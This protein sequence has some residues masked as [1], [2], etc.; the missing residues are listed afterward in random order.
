MQY[1]L[2]CPCNTLTG[3]EMIHLAQQHTRISRILGIA[4]N[5]RL[6]ADQGHL[7]DLPTASCSEVDQKLLL[8][9]EL[10]FTEDDAST[11]LLAS[12]YSA[13]FKAY[14]ESQGKRCLVLGETTSALEEL[15]SILYAQLDTWGKALASYHRDYLGGLSLLG[16]PQGELSRPGDILPELSADNPKFNYQTLRKP[17]TEVSLQ[18]ILKAELAVEENAGLWSDLLQQ[19]NLPK[20]SSGLRMRCLKDLN[21]NLVPERFRPVFMNYRHFVQSRE[22]DSDTEKTHYKKNSEENSALKFKSELTLYYKDDDQTDT[23]VLDLNNNGMLE[24]ISAIEFT[25]PKNIDSL[26]DEFEADD[27]WKRLVELRI[28]R[29]QHSFYIGASHPNLALTQKATLDFVHKIL[30][31]ALVYG[32]PLRH[33]LSTFF[34]PFEFKP[35]VKVDNK[36]SSIS[37]KNRNNDNDPVTPS[38]KASLDT[39]S[40]NLNKSKEKNQKCKPIDPYE[41]NFRSYI[42]SALDRHSSQSKQYFVDS[43]YSSL[44]DKEN[45]LIKE[46]HI[47]PWIDNDATQFIIEESSDQD[48]NLSDQVEQVEYLPVSALINRLRLY[49]FSNEIYILGITVSPALRRDDAYR[50]LFLEEY[51]KEHPVPPFSSP[52]LPLAN[53]SA[54]SLFSDTT[55]WWCDLFFSSDADF[56][57]IKELQAGSWLAFNDNFRK[58]TESYPGEGCQNSYNITKSAPKTG[59][60]GGETFTLD[61][62]LGQFFNITVDNEEQTFDRHKHLM[63]ISDHR[64][65]ISTCYGFGGPPPAADQAKQKQHQ[66]FSLA[67]YADKSGFDN[68][69]MKGYAYDPDF[70]SQH[71][72]KHRYNRWIAQGQVYGYTDYSNVYIGYGHYFCT[73][74]AKE[75][76]PNLYDSMLTVALFYRASLKHYEQRITDATRHFG[77][78]QGKKDFRLMR[79]D[80]LYFT[81]RYWYKELTDQV[82]GK[83]IFNLQMQGLDIEKNYHF[84]KDEVDTADDYIESENSKKFNQVGGAIALFTVFSMV[85]ST[86]WNDDN[87]KISSE[88]IPLSMGSLYLYIGILFYLLM[89]GP[90]FM[91]NRFILFSILG[92]VFS[93]AFM[94]LL[95]GYSNDHFKYLLEYLKTFNE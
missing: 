72:A 36:I 51:K 52:R 47:D 46:W 83:E 67:L 45:P 58:L 77:S 86:V 25:G 81:N 19:A 2:I 48:K 9:E 20:E 42:Q 11:V 8:A 57:R 95:W 35:G 79:K 56:K 15:A 28:L 3:R 65:F 90:R 60:I 93:L 74:I 13:E 12:Q 23:E 76:V 55:D 70:V 53:G 21:L 31:A 5:W 50:Y 64:M 22:I 88:L 75:N 92:G 17:D 85:F 16:I 33:Y 38:T 29:G 24:R 80:F 73:E 62:L 66:F 69:V 14:I 82:Q 59:H 41:G 91:S 87:E 26:A 34:L 18:A 94:G 1:T 71:I 10:R 39:N 44:N 32:R 84:I 37:D 6:P 61:S 49:K 7:L 43:I 78:K 4:G 40:D 30:E 68:A 54:S 63:P 27:H 89:V